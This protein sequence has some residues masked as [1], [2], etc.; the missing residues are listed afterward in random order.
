MQA[1]AQ[2]CGASL[3]EILLAILS[4]ALRRY[5]TE[6]GELPARSLVAGV[7]VASRSGFADPRHNAGAMILV[8]L[9]TDRAD[10]QDRLQGVVRS[11]ALAKEH[12]YTMSPAAADHY[13][14]LT[15]GPFMLQELARL[16]GR[17]NAP[18][19]VTLSN[20]AGPRE[21]RYLQ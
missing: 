8:N 20:V 15:F 14:V 19:N 4:G 16:S 17:V 5:L 11:S 7:P 12:L 10:P 3:N 21:Q 2:S 18:F 6:R 1:L 13:A 9:F